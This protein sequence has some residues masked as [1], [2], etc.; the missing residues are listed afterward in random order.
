MGVACPCRAIGNFS[1]S[2][3]WSFER[4]GFG[5]ALGFCHAVIDV[6][7]NIFILGAKI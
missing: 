3:F 2:C 4:V 1:R 6:Q 5:T 7:A